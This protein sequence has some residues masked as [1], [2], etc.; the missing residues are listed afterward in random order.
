[1]S[2]SA[3][4][5][6]PNFRQ[7]IYFP[8]LFPQFARPLLTLWMAC[9]ALIFYSILYDLEIIIPPLNNNV[10]RTYFDRG[11]IKHMI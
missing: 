3:S 11:G 8:D 5:I 4:N 10:N 1:M 6:L 7:F 9:K 2:Y